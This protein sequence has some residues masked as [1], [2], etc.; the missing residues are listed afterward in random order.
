MNHS[1]SDLMDLS[2][3][4]GVLPNFIGQSADNCRIYLLFP[5]ATHSQIG[6]DPDKYIDIVIVVR[7][8]RPL[9]LLTRLIRR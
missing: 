3:V 2:D 9:I 4:A 6:T 7:L 8:S 5:D 1:V